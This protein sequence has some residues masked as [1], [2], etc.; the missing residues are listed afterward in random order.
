MKFEKYL[1]PENKNEKGRTRQAMQDITISVATLNFVL[2]ELE[3]KTQEE[4]VDFL[5]QQE[6]HSYQDLDVFLKN[7]WPGVSLEDI[8]KY[9]PEYKEK[10]LFLENYIKRKDV[11]L[12]KLKELVQ[13]ILDYI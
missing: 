13:D 1:D 7:G 6:F 5:S 8:D 12:Q 9:F 4:L 11:E 3:S 2:S 10:Y